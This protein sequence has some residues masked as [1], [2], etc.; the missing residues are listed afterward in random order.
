M[1]DDD[2]ANVVYRCAY[3]LASEL[4]EAWGFSMQTGK[5]LSQ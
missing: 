2:S 3:G 1:T 5:S 4:M